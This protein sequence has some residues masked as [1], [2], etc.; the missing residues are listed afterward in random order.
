MLV[1][2]VINC[3]IYFYN[4]DAVFTVCGALPQNCNMVTS[5]LICYIYPFLMLLVFYLICA[6]LCGAVALVS[7]IVLPFILLELRVDR[8]FYLTGEKLRSASVLQKEWR[9]VQILFLQANNFFGIALIP[10]HTLFSKFTVICMYLILRHDTGMR[11]DTKIICK[12]WTFMSITFWGFVLMLGGLVHL[13]GGKVLTSWKYHKWSELSK[14]EKK[15]FSSF[16]RSCMPLA[17]A[18]GRTYVIRRL[19]VMKFF[20]QL[21]AGL[22]RALLTLKK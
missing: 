15:I 13:Y 17:I 10:M 1:A 16:R 14:K 3:I 9:I 22:L 21:S 11:D 8:K 19:S 4:L 6:G 5:I 20:R 7:F 12:I 2:C 18:Y